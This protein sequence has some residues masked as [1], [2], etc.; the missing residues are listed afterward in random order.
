MAWGNAIDL[1]EQQG[2]ILTSETAFAELSEVLLSILF[3]IAPK[4]QRNGEL[5]YH[6]FMILLKH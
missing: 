1:A 2:K 5:V 6:N 4:I 3:F